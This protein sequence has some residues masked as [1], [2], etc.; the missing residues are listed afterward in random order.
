M[1]PRDLKE[2][3]VYAWSGGTVDTVKGRLLVW[4]GGHSDYWGNE[5]YALDVASLRLIKGFSL[6]ELRAAMVGHVLDEAELI[7]SYSLN[8]AVAG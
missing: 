1:S 7:G 3:I 8:P 6:A 2:G 4:G 5:L